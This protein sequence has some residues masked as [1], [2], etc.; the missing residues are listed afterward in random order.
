MVTREG[1]DLSQSVI[2]YATSRSPC[3]LCLLVPFLRIRVSKEVRRGTGRS[4]S[5]S[6]NWSLGESHHQLLIFVPFLSQFLHSYLLKLSS[7]LLLPL[8][9]F[10]PVFPRILLTVLWTF[11]F[12][13]R[14]NWLLEYTVLCLFDFESRTP[15]TWSRFASLEGISCTG[16]RPAATTNITRHI[17]KNHFNCNFRSDSIKFFFPFISISFLLHRS[18]TLISFISAFFWFLPSSITISDISYILYSS[19][20]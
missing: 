19:V 8:L 9:N 12:P 7:H 5:P 17:S 14:L 20:L 18:V 10:F 16:R 1:Q 2:L 6:M 13:S 4:P 15:P 3:R 11:T